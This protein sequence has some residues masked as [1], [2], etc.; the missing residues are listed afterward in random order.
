ME[1]DSTETERSNTTIMH[2]EGSLPKYDF[3]QLALVTDNG[4]LCY[5]RILQV[6]ID[7]ELRLKI[8]ILRVISLTKYMH[9]VERTECRSRLPDT[10]SDSRDSNDE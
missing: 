3:R 8:H 10:E 6:N 9:V 5:A 2:I 1:G 7:K 4:G